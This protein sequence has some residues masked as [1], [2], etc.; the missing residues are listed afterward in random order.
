MNEFVAD[1]P[2]EVDGDTVTATNGHAARGA[3]RRRAG[4]DGPKTRD[5]ARVHFGGMMPSSK[6]Q[7]PFKGASSHLNY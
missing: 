6:M 3:K 4:S 5:A 7:R 1:L 2:C